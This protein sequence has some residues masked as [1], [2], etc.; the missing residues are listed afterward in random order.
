MH[1]GMAACGCPC[2]TRRRVHARD[3]D[4]IST[5]SVY[6]DS[7][8]GQILVAH[9]LTHVLL[10][11]SDV[12]R[13]RH[14][15]RK[16]AANEEDEGEDNDSPGRRDPRAD[17]SILQVASR[18]TSAWNGLFGQVRGPKCNRQ[19]DAVDYYAPVGTNTHAVTGGRV[20]HR[21]MRGYGTSIFLHESGSDTVYLYAHLS[22]QTGEPGS[23]VAAGENIGETG[24]SGNANA[25]RLHLHFEVHPTGWQASADP[26]CHEF[27]TPTH[28]RVYTEARQWHVTDFDIDDCNCY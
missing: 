16:A 12:H 21:E 25:E 5:W 23:I 19:H 17:P 10:Q 6:S 28:Q 22:D 20:Q 11:T 9:E 8:A 1:T 18:V 15:Q 24:V 26:L 4:R 27:P 14:I 2:N 13:S 3:E 7:R